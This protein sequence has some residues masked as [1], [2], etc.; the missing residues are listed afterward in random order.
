MRRQIARRAF[1]LI[2]LIVVIAIILLLCGLLLCAV[3][4]VRCASQ[5]SA[6]SNNLKQIGL[7]VQNF[8]ATNSNRIPRED[9]VFGFVD[10]PLEEY[11]EKSEKVLVCP[12]AV[13][14]NMTGNPAITYGYNRVY[15]GEGVG[16][17]ILIQFDTSETISFADAAN[18]VGANW[19]PVP[20]FTTA[21]FPPSDHWP[22]IRYLHV[23]TANVLFLDGSVRQD[24]TKTR[25]PLS[26]YP[27][28]YWFV[29]QDW[30]E[31]GEK[32]DIYTIG[33][34]GE[35]IDTLWGKK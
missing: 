18:I 23:G 24:R 26:S 1:T 35:L 31:C 9:E 30:V 11:T 34:D 29:T 10:N 28:G 12:S 6:C 7:A 5:R 17:K 22:S 25:T 21:I 20:A 2:E 13:T 14:P 4:K 16:R 19:Q 15:L 3:Q 8:A 32:N 27:A 33:V